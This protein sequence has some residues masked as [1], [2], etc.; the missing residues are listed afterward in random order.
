V[1]GPRRRSWW[2]TLIARPENDPEEFVRVHGMRAGDIMTRD[3]IT[4]G[5]D[6]SVEEIAR[7]LEE[8]RIRRVP[9][10]RDGRLAGI[11]SRADLLRVL[12]AAPPQTPATVDDEAL[13]QRVV[14]A[15]ARQEWAHVSLLSVAASDGVVHLSGFLFSERERPALVVAAE[16]VPGVRQVVDELQAVPR[17]VSGF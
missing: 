7:I 1:G 13:R 2:H 15:L 6:T 11:V 14:D 10:V 16:E 9:V 8:R 4:V 17:T 5:E 12:V 3:V